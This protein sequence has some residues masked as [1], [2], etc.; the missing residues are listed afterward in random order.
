MTAGPIASPP[1]KEPTKQPTN[2][3]R[4]DRSRRAAGKKEPPFGSPNRQSN[5]PVAAWNSWRAGTN[6]AGPR[7]RAPTA[8]GAAHWT[9]A[10]VR[11]SARGGWVGYFV[12]VFVGLERRKIWERKQYK[13]KP[14]GERERERERERDGKRETEKKGGLIGTKGEGTLRTRPEEEEMN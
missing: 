4:T 14:R 9:T 12:E 6:A 8:I 10:A 13:T 1:N 3:R 2:D 7:R 11:P 5:L